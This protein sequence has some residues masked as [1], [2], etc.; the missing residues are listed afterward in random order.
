MELYVFRCGAVC[1]RAFNLLE[2]QF[3]KPWV[4][5]PHSAKED[6]LSL[7]HSQIACLCL[8]IKMNNKH[9]YQQSQVPQWV[10]W[11]EC[12]PSIGMGYWVE[13]F[14]LILDMLRRFVSGHSVCWRLCSRD[15]EFEFYLKQ[16]E[17][18]CLLSIKKPL[19]CATALISTTTN[20]YIA[21][22]RCGSQLEL[23]RVGWM[24]A[25]LRDRLLSSNF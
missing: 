18:T 16:R 2:I 8:N 20:M 15:P 21:R 13:V 1:K 11:A 17:T 6:N 7:F 10:E 4:W 25:D 23:G 9:V 12:S 19:A 5:I 22:A 24:F 3:Q 14:S